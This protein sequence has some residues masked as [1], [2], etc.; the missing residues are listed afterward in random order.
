MEG[1]GRKR[2]ECLGGGHTRERARPIDHFDHRGAQM[3]WSRLDIRK[4]VLV[5]KGVLSLQ[6]TFDQQM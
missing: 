1:G 4:V 2:L 6:S 3:M 5:I